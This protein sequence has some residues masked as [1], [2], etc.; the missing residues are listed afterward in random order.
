M[1]LSTASTS[2]EG[3]DIASLLDW[4]FCLLKALEIDKDPHHK[5]KTLEPCAVNQDHILDSSK[6]RVSYP[7]F[8][9][10]DLH[11][12]FKGCHIPL[13]KSGVVIVLVHMDSTVHVKHEIPPITTV[14]QGLQGQEDISNHGVHLIP[15]KEMAVEGTP[16]LTPVLLVCCWVKRRY[17]LAGITKLWERV[18]KNTKLE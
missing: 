8:K 13:S 15:P 11:G 14:V 2:L 16:G 5:F 6:G 17:C 3:R 9:V 10:V 1:A 4:G 18:A 12:F 7:I